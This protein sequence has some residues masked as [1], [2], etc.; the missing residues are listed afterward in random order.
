M[1]KIASFMK[2]GLAVHRITYEFNFSF[3]QTRTWT[4]YNKNKAWLHRL[5]LSKRT[6]PAKKKFCLCIWLSVLYRYPAR[7]SKVLL[8]NSSQFP[9]VTPGRA[10][11]ITRN[12]PVDF[13]TASFTASYSRSSDKT[14]D[15]L[16]RYPV[17]LQWKN[18]LVWSVQCVFMVCA[19]WPIGLAHFRRSF[20]RS[21][22][23][24]LYPIRL[25][26]VCLP[27]ILW[28]AQS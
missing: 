4:L 14:D 19:C 28:E 13:L 24:H 27:R 2:W 18:L 16:Y 20:C 15:Q 22:C 17:K 5:C 1:A 26:V 10:V 25:V 11:A 9:A 3:A 21:A 6:S 7:H 23:P 12:R 8:T